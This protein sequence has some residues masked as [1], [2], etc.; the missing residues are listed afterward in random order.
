MEN[1]LMKKISFEVARP[2]L[3]FKLYYKLVHDLGKIS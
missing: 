2:E 1:S 3:K